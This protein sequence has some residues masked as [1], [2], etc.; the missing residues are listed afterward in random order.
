M[1]LENLTLLKE[2][3]DSKIKIWKLYKND[4]YKKL[5]KVLKIKTNKLLKLN[6]N[7][8]IMFWGWESDYERDK[9]FFK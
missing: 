3:Y 4:Y 8:G 1:S 5:E 6:F 9:K 2:I 7:N